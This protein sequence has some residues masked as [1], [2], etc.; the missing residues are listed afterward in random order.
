M[1][2]EVEALWAFHQRRLK[3]GTPV[4][5]LRDRVAFSQDP[6]WR[7]VA[8]EDCGLLYRNPAERAFELESIYERDCPARELLAAL[9]ETQRKSYDAQARRLRELL[10]RGARVLEVGSYVGAF[11]A[12]ARDAGLNAAGV[13]INPAVNR[14]T[15]SLG[16]DVRDGELPEMETDPVDAI[17]IWNTFDQLSDPRGVAIAAFARLKPGGVLAIRVPNGDYYRRMRPGASAGRRRAVLAHNN[18]LTFPYRWGFS[19]SALRTLLE[20]TGFREVRSIGD[21]LVPTADEWTRRWA[22]AEEWVVKRLMR[23]VG[24]PAADRSPWFEQYATVPPSPA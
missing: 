2:R 9:H 20:E 18:L 4:A 17:A 21:V 16:F 10:P 12:A 11:L 5:R 15:R 13:D 23:G 7:L 6:P 19:P 14:F 24:A 22:R 8:C 3:P 1:R